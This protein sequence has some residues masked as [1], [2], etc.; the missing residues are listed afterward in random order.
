MVPTPISKVNIDDEFWAP[1]QETN[2]RVTV[3]FLYR[4]LKD[5]GCFDALRLEWRP[6]MPNPPHIFWESDIAKWLEAASY[7]LMTRADSHL[8]QI[9][10]NVIDLLAA[11]QQPD[12]YL[13][14]HFTVVEPGKRWSNLRDR[15][16][17]YC[18]GHL[19]EAAVAHFE[20][21]RRTSL[22]DVL[23]RYANHI[24]TVFGSD[25]GQKR[26]YPGHEEIEL[27]LVKLYRATGEKRYLRLAKFFIDERGQQPHYFEIEARERGE[28]PEQRTDYPWN[29]GQKYDQFQAH[30]P[31]RQ[32]RTAEGHAVRAMYLFS[33]MA[34]VAMETGDAELFEACRALWRNVMSRRMY[35]TG[36]VGPSSEGERFTIDYDLPNDTAYAE[37]CAAIGLVMWAHR[38]LQVEL[39]RRY[40]DVMERALYNGVISGVSL[41]GDTF[42][43]VNPLAVDPEAPY[44]KKRQRIKPYRQEWFDTACCPPNIARLLA[45]LG[46]YIYSTGDGSLAVH[47]YVQSSVA[48]HIG[49]VAVHLHQ[50]TK[51]PWQGKVTVTVEPE[52]PVAFD[53]LLRVPGWCTTFSLLVN[54][55]PV[56]APVENG[57]VRITKTWQTGDQAE[58]DM[59]MPVQRIY[60]HPS[61][62]A[63]AGRVALQR[64]PI[65]YCLEE[66]DNGTGLV[67]LGLSRDA[68]LETTFERD[69]LGGVVTIS[70]QAVRF[71]SCDWGDDLYR[72]HESKASLMRFKA[73]PYSVW[74]N[75][76]IGEML[77]WINEARGGELPTGIQAN[78]E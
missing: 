18:A 65:V 72:T 58:L 50:K 78:Q 15:H 68:R 45:S 32:Q 19:M 34:D 52:R 16:E 7:S 9:L 60:A 31:V 57:Y 5:N 63:T 67:E 2:T 41:Q 46:Q 17:L 28:V 71:Q 12:G 69:L 30:L 33:G 77:V 39:D 54:G 75:R 26:G 1:R 43:Y 66:A 35:V 3:P 37:T 40:A 20:A 62:V 6:D 21:T 13:N 22:L 70:G 27:A 11:A 55:S 24:E 10:D 49:G 44:F 4:K 25:S 59:E 53:L 61:V 36:G 23:R 38:M 47:L 64:G 48:S 74:A 8:E 76:C 42:F 73:V 29:L 14:V 56:R 51:Y